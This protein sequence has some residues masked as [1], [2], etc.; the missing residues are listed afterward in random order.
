MEKFRALTT[1]VFPQ[2]FDSQGLHVNI[3]LIPRNHNPFTEFQVGLNPSQ[4]VPPFSTL[5]P[6]FSIGIVKGLDD[7]PLANA[8]ADER[9]PRM[10]EV[11][12]KTAEKKEMMLNGIA[13]IFDR[14]KITDNTDRLGEVVG[15]NF[16]VKKFLPES[17]RKSFNFT[18]P[19]HPNAVTDDSYACDMKK[20]ADVIDN[21]TPKDTLSWGKVF[22]HILKQPLLARAC[23]MIYEVVIPLDSEEI[24]KGGYIYVDILNEG[25]VEVQHATLEH[26]DGPLIKRYAARIPKLE[27]GSERPVFAPILFPVLYRKNNQS[28]FDAVPPAPWDRLFRE[29]MTY[30]DGFAKIVHAGQAVSTDLLKETSDGILP[31]FETGI[32][33]AWDDEQI[34]IW[35]IRQLVENESDI[36][37]NGKRVDVP[38][39][40]IGYKIDVREQELGSQWESLNRSY[41]NKGVLALA[42]HL[43]DGIVE[44]PYQV[45]PSKKRSLQPNP[46]WLPMY[47]A[48]WVGKSMVVEDAD[49]LEIYKNDQLNKGFIASEGMDPENGQSRSIKN[50]VLAAP[51][52]NTQLRYG[53]TYQFRV[54]M[55]DISGG[56]P[57]LEDE[58]LHASPSPATTVSFKRYLG[59]ANLK[60]VKPELIT[61]FKAQI[62]NAANIEETE[63]LDDQ[64]LRISRPLMEYPAVV[65]TGKYQQRGMDPVEMLKNLDFNGDNQLVLGI[66]DPDANRVEFRVEVQSLSMDNSLSEN[67]DEPYL[68]LYTT[69]R[70]FSDDFFEEMEVPVQF[71][72]VPVL[73]LE[74]QANPF[75]RD[76]L[77]QED[78]D[79]MDALVLPSSRKVRVSLRALADG[80]E[81]DDVSYF[82]FLND[83]NRDIDSRYGK[84]EQLLFY[85]E[86]TSETDLLVPYKNIPVLQALHLKAND[87]PLVKGSLKDILKFHLVKNR[88][89][90][91]PDIVLRFASALG[92]QAKGLTVYA[93]KGERIVFGVSSRIRHSLA[94]D[95]SSVTFASRAELQDHWLGCLSFQ[96]NRDWAWD[97]LDLTSFTIGK[98]TAFRRDV[99]E[100]AE[101]SGQGADFLSRKLK[102]AL[103]AHFN[104]GGSQD[105]Q[106]IIE[107]NIGDI[108]MVRTASFE[109]LQQDRFGNVRRDFTRII[110]IDAIEPKSPFR[111]KGNTN[112]RLPDEIWIDYAIKIHAKALHPEVED[113]LVEDLKLP[114]VLIPPQVPKIVSVGLAFSPYERAEDYSSTEVRSRHLWVEFEEAIEN[115]DDTYFCRVLVTSPDQLIST[116]PLEQ[117]VSE[118]EPEIPLDPEYTR[119]VLPGQ[120]DDLAG[121]TAMQ[122][123]IKSTDSDR[124]YILPLPPGLHAESPELFGF[125]TYEFRVG[126]THWAN[127]DDNLWSTAQGRFG[128]SIRVTGIQHPVPSLLCSVNRDVDSLYV[129][130]PF[131]KAVIKGKNVTADPPRTSLWALLYTQVKQADAKDHRNILLAERLMRH[132]FRKEEAKEL[133]SIKEKLRKFTFVNADTHLNQQPVS[134]K[135]NLESMELGSILALKKGLHPVGIAAFSSLEIAGLLQD[136][137]LPEDS[138]LSVLAVEVFG[139]ITNFADHIRSFGRGLNNLLIDKS[140]YEKLRKINERNQGGVASDSLSSGLG[141]FRILRT[142]PLTKVPFVCCP[143]CEN[144]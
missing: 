100:A 75:L 143:T 66:P 73:N 17:Y 26:E 140:E 127:Q 69:T 33:L 132:D 93:P 79:N 95:G 56:G 54:R 82:G 14:Y 30:D 103:M 31:Q 80:G 4:I 23:G 84:V 104:Y 115:P 106:P 133:D 137:G 124:H 108:E 94:P 97:A 87:T 141:H 98:S 36:P 111:R 38:L 24:E 6:Q 68:T 43:D 125:F 18:R 28:D 35:Y 51:Q 7:F 1:M 122:P 90:S 91:I 120:S 139:N 128:K 47:F 102:N 10:L 12:V 81:I 144:Y 126:H 59:P 99:L 9:K 20:E 58:P 49:A 88:T 70:T 131:A 21:Y 34:L 85:K 67:G 89:Q 22:A 119:I 86:S 110:F 19:A 135:L 64:V 8:S 39:G 123:M 71:I 52:V 48:N 11:A 92:L 60:I 55:A 16:S 96:V 114:T 44:L 53:K 40:V 27:A 15:V 61:T 63:F 129:S 101:E 57:A 142:S 118:E 74:E 76:D 77:K 109:S 72:D 42:D 130:A 62:F 138:P 2:R 32:R 116:N 83:N 112:P 13:D 78:L 136:L 65:F 50:N 5:N 113:V 107:P 3:V 25:W 29:A 134:V 105:P 45:F 37:G 117:F 41:I 46:Y 121:I